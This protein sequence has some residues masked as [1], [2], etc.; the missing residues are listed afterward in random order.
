MNIADIKTLFRTIIVN[1]C[2]WQFIHKTLKSAQVKQP[3]FPVALNLSEPKQVF[4]L[5]SVKKK[6]KQDK[7]SISHYHEPALFYW[8]AYPGLVNLQLQRLSNTVD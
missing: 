1:V 7:Q 6:T 8:M 2:L 3:L 5:P 4:V